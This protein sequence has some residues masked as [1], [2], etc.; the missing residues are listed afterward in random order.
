VFIGGMRATLPLHYHDKQFMTPDRIEL[1][2]RLN[3][4]S[5]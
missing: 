4:C 2:E 1:L 3:V 5:V